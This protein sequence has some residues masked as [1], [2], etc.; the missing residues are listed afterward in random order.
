MNTT[1]NNKFRKLTGKINWLGKASC[2]KKKIKAERKPQSGDN[3][4][5]H[6]LMNR[7]I[8]KG[9]GFKQWSIIQQ[10]KRDEALIHVTQW[11]NLENMMLR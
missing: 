2:L 4:N 11:I 10:L 5:V 1:T 7:Q 6:Q 9:S 3:P 8:K